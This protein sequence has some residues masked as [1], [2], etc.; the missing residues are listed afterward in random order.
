MIGIKRAGNI[1][2]GLFI[3]LYALFFLPKIGY[4]DLKSIV[5]FI[6]FCLH[7]KNSRIKLGKDSLIK[8]IVFAIILL[9]LLFLINALVHKE[10]SVG[11]ALRYA[12]ALFSIVCLGA[13][14]SG[15]EIDKQTFFKTLFCVMALHMVAIYASMIFPQTR[16]LIYVL[17]GY[18]TRELRLRSSGLVSGY[19]VAGY[20]LNALFFINVYYNLKYKNK[21]FS[22]YTIAI[23]IA[24]VFTSRINTLLLI[25]QVFLFS[26]YLLRKKKLSLGSGLLIIIPI[27]LIG[28]V[29]SFLTLDV[30]AGIK[31]SLVERVGWIRALNKI[32]VYSYSNSKV[33]AAASTHYKIGSDVN[34]VLGNGIKAPYDPGIINTI[35]EGGIIALVIKVACYLTVGL[36]AFGR[37]SKSEYSYIIIYLVILTTF[38]ESKLVFYFA[39]G[40]FELMLIFVYLFQSECFSKNKDNSGGA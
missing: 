36:K 37:R 8:G 23:I 3:V 16:R 18:K 35:Y 9:L 10:A 27:V 20:Y 26:V 34:L 30:F 2:W 38:F 29:F 12:R 24:T 33:V 13:Y 15:K 1:D 25:L 28:G 40:V 21:P 31:Q 11:I 6:V 32:V 22:L 39:S 19:D 4:I 17:S 7:I 5:L 14:L